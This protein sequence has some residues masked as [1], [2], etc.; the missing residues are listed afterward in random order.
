MSSNNLKK[1]NSK[2]GSVIG[3]NLHV[4]TTQNTTPHPLPENLL[5]DTTPFPLPENLLLDTSP[6]LLPENLL[7]DNTPLP[8]AVT[9]RIQTPYHPAEAILYSNTTS[10]SF[11][12]NILDSSGK[13]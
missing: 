13:L 10:S 9:R 6:L 11:V 7:L 2:K 8:P 4:E 1:T 5:L 3:E 12:E